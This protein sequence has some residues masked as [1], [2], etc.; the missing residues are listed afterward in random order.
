MHKMVFA[1]LP[2]LAACCAPPQAPLTTGGGPIAPA[3]APAVPVAEAAPQDTPRSYPP[4]RTGEMSF[5]AEKVAKEAGCYRTDSAT[6]VAQRTGIQFYRVP[7]DSGRQMLV[8]CEL[9]QCR[10]AD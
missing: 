9:R 6:V 8:R 2:L 4:A 7:C 1:F 3:T 5:A 10:I